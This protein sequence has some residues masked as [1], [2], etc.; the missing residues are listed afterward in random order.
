MERKLAAILCADV[1]DYSRLR[2]IDEAGT[3]VALKAHREEL[4]EF[5]MPRV[6]GLADAPLHPPTGRRFAKGKI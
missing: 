1:V 4:I 6:R 3:L 2:E 5:S